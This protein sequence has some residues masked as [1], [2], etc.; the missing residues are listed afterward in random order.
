MIDPVTEQYEIMKYYDKHAIM[1]ANL[2]ETKW[3]TMYPSPIET[4]YDQ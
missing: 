3:L 1:I 4:S 2:V